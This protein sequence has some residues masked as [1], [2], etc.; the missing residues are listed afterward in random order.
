MS[1]RVFHPE[2]SL[3][4]EEYFKKAGI[5]QV[6]AAKLLNVTPQAVSLQLKQPFGKNVSSKWE[7]AFG[8]NRDFLMTGN[9]ELIAPREPIESAQTDSGSVNNSSMHK[10]EG[11]AQKD[12][13][14]ANITKDEAYYRNL[15]IDDFVY[16]AKWESTNDYMLAQEIVKAFYIQLNAIKAEIDYYKRELAKL[17]EEKKNLFLE[18]A[19]LRRLIHKYKGQY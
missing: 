19:T 14:S 9:G 15:D 11:P 2:V 6:M 17:S 7:K 1:N 4:I 18:N 10:S 5:S 12:D 13:T 16:D 3:A 8:F